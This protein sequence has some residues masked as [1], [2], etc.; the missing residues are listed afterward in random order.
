MPKVSLESLAKSIPRGNNPDAAP[1][2]LKTIDK[3]VSGVN[4]ML[5]TYTDIAGKNKPASVIEHDAS[6]TPRSF[7][8]ARAEK[9]AEMSGK[10]A[11]L[12][13]GERTEKMPNEFKELLDGIIKT[14]QTYSGMG[15]GDKKIGE[16][17]LELPVTVDQLTVFLVAL[18]LKRYGE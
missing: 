3:V 6:E 15:S 17:V 14:L 1:D 4:D 2:W 8:E 12:T 10:P 16:A 13:S 7:H 9:K 18:R 5:K 11:V